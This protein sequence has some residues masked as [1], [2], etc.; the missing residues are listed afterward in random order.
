MSKKM[1]LFIV[2]TMLCLVFSGYSQPSADTAALIKEFNKVLAFTVRPFLYYSTITK[3]NAVPVLGVEDTGSK[4][5]EYYKNGDNIYYSN[6]KDEIF[7]EDSFLVQVNHDHKTIWISKV[8][9]D[10]KEKMNVLPLTNKNV[11]EI[12]RKNYSISRTALGNGVARLNFETKGGSGISGVKTQIRLEFN[13]N[14]FLPRKMEIEVN[15]QEPAEDELLELLRNEGVD[16][17][18]TVQVIDN[19]KYIIRKQ[20]LTIIFSDMDTSREKAFQAPTWKGILDFNSSGAV[21]TG[22]GIYK[23]YEVTKTF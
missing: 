8:D 15:M 14:D 1:S 5:G 23:E 21:F 16:A 2:T 13:E 3:M 10:V 4:R 22:K 6:Q 12:F 18:Q 19:E 17:M 9:K 20:Q 7:L 11:S